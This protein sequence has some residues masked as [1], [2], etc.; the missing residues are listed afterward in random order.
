L[1][2][3]GMYKT[4]YLYTKSLIYYLALI[5]LQ[6]IIILYVFTKDIIASITITLIVFSIIT[7]YY[8]IFQGKII[9]TDEGIKTRTHLYSWDEVEHV[10]VYPNKYII[11]CLKLPSG[12]HRVGAGIR[13]RY[14]DIA[15]Y[16]IR[17]DE[18]LI[19]IF[20]NKANGKV[21]IKNIPHYSF[22]SIIN[23]LKNIKN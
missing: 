22:S 16:I 5:V 3:R 4:A 19:D 1:G 12:I 6:S 20:K 2:G 15:E 8:Y 21:Q 11:L 10:Y 13:V 9:L 18:D 7:T 14:S 17:Y 23:C